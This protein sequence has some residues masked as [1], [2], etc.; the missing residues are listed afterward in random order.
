VARRRR[1]APRRHDAGV[2]FVLEVGER[3]I[4]LTL[5][6][7]DFFPDAAPSILARDRE[8]LSSH[9][10]GPSGELC[11][12]HRPDNWTPDV[13]GA[14]M[15]ESAH[16]LLSV[17]EQ[18]GQ[19]AP[20]EHRVTRAQR[21]RYSTFRF[22]Y[23][24]DTL[25]WLGMVAEG[26]VAEGEMQEQDTA[27]T[28]VAQLSRIGTADAPLWREPTAPIVRMDLQDRST[29]SHWSEQKQQALAQQFLDTVMA[30]CAQ[31]RVPREVGWCEAD[32]RM[33][34]LADIRDG[35]RR[36][37]RVIPRH[38]RF[39]LHQRCTSSGS[40]SPATGIRTAQGN[41]FGSACSNW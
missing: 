32:H 29:A 19:P 1:D 30:L 7:P 26:T 25:S 4:P 9:Q 35:T 27:G 3:R 23:F 28:Y 12:E 18:T 2:D 8:L 24:K 22:L 6:Y 33:G 14:M 37:D 10:Y 36:H 20:A 21:M 39:A 17:E 31:H 5:V 16:R 38:L 34:E 15:I 13:T 11:L 40:A 41:F